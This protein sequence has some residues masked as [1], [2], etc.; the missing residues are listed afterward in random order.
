[1]T[2][3]QVPVGV[4]FRYEDGGKIAWRVGPPRTGQPSKIRG[5][6]VLQERIPGPDH[7]NVEILWPTLRLV[8]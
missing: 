5:Q 6:F 3:G 7:A 8:P 1:M 2:R 4:V